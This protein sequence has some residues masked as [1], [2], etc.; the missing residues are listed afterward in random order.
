MCNQIRPDRRKFN[1]YRVRCQQRSW[2]LLRETQVRAGE[3]VQLWHRPLANPNLV[4]MQFV[5]EVRGSDSS[6]LDAVTASS[7]PRPELMEFNTWQSWRRDFGERPTVARD[8]CST[9]SGF[10]ATLWRETMSALYGE[11]WQAELCERQAA[12]QL[13]EAEVLEAAPALGAQ[14]SGARSCDPPAAATGA[15][16]RPTQARASPFEKWRTT[17]PQSPGN[18]E[19]GTRTPE[20]RPAEAPLA[21]P[22]SGDPAQ[23]G[24]ASPG[25]GGRVSPASWHSASPGSPP[26]LTCRIYKP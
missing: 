22:G 3:P 24:P 23:A 13:A 15:G 17:P 10:E 19:Q 20:R 14:A 18:V 4:T 16:E 8:G 26:T 1:C 12:A 6:L 2:G 21:Q 11:S 7:V 25:S 5:Q 9:T